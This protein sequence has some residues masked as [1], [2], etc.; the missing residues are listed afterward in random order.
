MLLLSADVAA[1]HPHDGHYRP[2]TTA[3]KRTQRLGEVV[4]RGKYVDRV[5]KSAY[6]A[7]AIDTR[8]LRNTNLDLA[9]AL[10][11]VA[12]IKIREEGGVGSAVQLNLNGFTGQHV[13]VFIDACR[14]TTPTPASD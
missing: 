13:K 10:D 12:G 5:N 2:D 9:H 6:N 4:V 14:W 3:L 7:V 11:R 1:Q 8:K